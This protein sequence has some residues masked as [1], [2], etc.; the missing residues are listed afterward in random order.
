[1]PVG[2]WLCNRITWFGR[3]IGEW[4]MHKLLMRRVTSPAVDERLGWVV[5]FL[6]LVV[7]T[8]VMLK[9]VPTLGLLTSS[10]L[11]LCVSAGWLVIGW[12]AAGVWSG[13][14]RRYT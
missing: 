11:V 6:F 9:M 1:L 5:G 14:T 13:L 10:V 7:C 2:N 3:P 12:E 8:T 4:V